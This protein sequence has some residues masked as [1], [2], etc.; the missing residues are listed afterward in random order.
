MGIIVQEPKLSKKGV[1]K[2]VLKLAAPELFE[3]YP[4]PSRQTWSWKDPNTLHYHDVAALL[5]EAR[6]SVAITLGAVP[7]MHLAKTP[8]AVMWAHNGKCQCGRRSYLFGWCSKCL[9]DEKL[10][11]ILR[12]HGE[13]AGEEARA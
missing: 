4:V 2:E 11:D 6:I 7:F 5:M 8:T 13:V 3:E 9:Q 1:Q 10:E 12:H